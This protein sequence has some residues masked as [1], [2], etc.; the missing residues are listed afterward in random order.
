[1]ST[2]KR[3]FLSGVI[4][5]AVWCYVVGAM[6]EWSERSARLPPR[7]GVSVLIVDGFYAG[8]SGIVVDRRGAW[9]LG[10]AYQVKLSQQDAVMVEDGVVTVR[11]E[12]LEV[13]P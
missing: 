8:K 12:E 10:F 3:Y 13:L 4:A 6:L 5:G 2:S 7:H 9:P 1:M 11:P